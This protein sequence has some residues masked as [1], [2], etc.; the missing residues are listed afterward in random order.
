M[1][2]WVKVVILTPQKKVSAAMFVLGLTGK[3]S[4]KVAK[5]CVCVCRG[6][7]G[8][9]GQHIQANN[10]SFTGK[11]SSLQLSHTGSSR[12][13]W[14]LHPSEWERKRRNYLRVLSTLCLSWSKFSLPGS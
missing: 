12:A 11:H 10:S 2:T 8:N 3:C 7:A 13:K 4:I 1:G 5:V 14:L 9:E 6:E